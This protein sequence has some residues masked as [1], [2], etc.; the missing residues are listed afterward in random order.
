MP[1]KWTITLKI[2]N[3]KEHGFKLL[4]LKN[5]E[6]ILWWCILDLELNVNMY[7]PNTTHQKDSF[8]LQEIMCH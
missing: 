4:V 3:K 8:W 1:K 7:E 6:E 5:S 2:Y